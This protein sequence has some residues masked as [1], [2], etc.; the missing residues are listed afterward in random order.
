MLRNILK[1]LNS[2]NTLSWKICYFLQL[3]S[4]VDDKPLYVCPRV[5]R[6]TPWSRRN[7]YEEEGR[8]LTD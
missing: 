1:E 6:C 8:L 7:I 2:I 3:L 4:V 5:L